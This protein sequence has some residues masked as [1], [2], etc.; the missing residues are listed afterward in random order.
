MGLIGVGW[1]CGLNHLHQ[2]EVSSRTKTRHETA[3][4]GLNDCVAWRQS[5][6][7]RRTLTIYCRRQSP[8]KYCGPHTATKKSLV[9]SSNGM[10]FIESTC[11]IA[12][13]LRM[14]SK[15]RRKRKHW[16]NPLL[17]QIF[18]HTDQAVFPI[19]KINFSV[20]KTMCD[21]ESSTADSLSDIIQYQ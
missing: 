7:A 12:L 17:S 9:Y 18:C 16:V 10:D 15:K 19:Q 21:G 2:N 20:S 13:L 11:V 3:K 14:K 6:K 4:W 1:Q 8:K 5:C